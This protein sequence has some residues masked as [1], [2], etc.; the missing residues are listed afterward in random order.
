MSKLIVIISCI[1]YFNNE[2]CISKNKIDFFTFQLVRLDFSFYFI[3][4]HYLHIYYVIFIIVNLSV[5]RLFFYLSR[6]KCLTFF[7]S[8]VAE[9]FTRIPIII[10]HGT[11]SRK[12]SMECSAAANKLN[13]AYLDGQIYEFCCFV[14]FYF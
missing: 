9:S 2:Q 12:F 6:N 13:V 1:R 5:S 4:V 14:N 3:F 11:F 10:D 8:I 7:S